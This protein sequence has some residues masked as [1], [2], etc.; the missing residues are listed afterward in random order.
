MWLWIRANKGRLLDAAVILAYAAITIITVSRHEPWRDESQAWLVARDAGGVS[1]IIREALYQRHPLLWYF[2]LAPFAQSGLPV[3]AMSLIHLAFAFSAV[4]LFVSNAPF[5]RFTKYLFIFSYFM[6]Y[7][8]AVLAREY[9]L[10]V[11]FLFWIASYYPKRWEHP[12]RYGWLI[13]F[14]FNTTYVCY[15]FGWGFLLLYAW[16]AWG[17]K[18]LGWRERTAV[19]IM[20]IGAVAVAMQ[21]STLPLDHADYG[22]VMKPNYGGPLYLM[23][24]AL[25]P[26]G[27]DVTDRSAMA[28][29][30][31]AIAGI[32][33][34]LLKKPAAWFLM[35]A[36][37][38]GLFYIFTFK[39]PG[40]LRHYGFGL[41][42]ILTA[43]WISS[44]YPGWTWMEKL[45]ERISPFTLQNLRNYSF[46]AIHICLILSIRF[47]Y[48]AHHLDRKADFS[49]GKN[50]AHFLRHFA[51]IGLTRDSV[52]AAHPSSQAV[53]VLVHLPG[54]KFWY[55]AVDEF[56]T[57]AKFTKEQDQNERLS[58]RDTLAKIQASFPDLS[59]IFLL[60]P[61]ALPF[62]EA[63]GYQ[64]R[65]LHAADQTVYGYGLER[66]YFY[67]VIKTR[68]EGTST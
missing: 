51:K 56:G 48:M 55:P 32:W 28:V 31:A 53:S 40:H 38:L 16:E 37:Y 36:A 4:I 20:L 67:Q 50:M 9:A 46:F 23:R 60:F 39:H 27:F 52:I 42:S 14:L 26:L 58:V 25:I 68:P 35:T 33:I 59:K 5:S 11:F 45:F 61:A 19:G 1:G 34:S 65:L 3:Q 24:K 13:F 30:V 22:Y 10:A 54:W 17:E 18:K 6:V 62:S 41:I 2:L 57:F 8:Y 47:G 12:L 64:F 43:L 29:A 63:H 66:F 49:G 15:F 7:E 21:G 44:Y